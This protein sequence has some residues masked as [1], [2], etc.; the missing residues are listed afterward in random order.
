MSRLVWGEAGTRLFEIGVNRGV[1]YPPN[2][3]A[4]VAWN[5]L[6]AVKES[7]SG[8][9]PQAYYQDGVKYFQIASAEEFDATIEAFS[10]PPEFALCD[11]TANV[12]AGLFITQQ[13][14]KQFG[15]SYCTLVGNDL[16]AE[17]YGY[18]IHLVYGA[19]A[20]PA[21]RSNDTISAS[22]EPMELS[23]DVTTVPQIVPGFKPSAHLIIDSRLATPA[24]LEALENMLY[25]QEGISPRLP[26][27]Q[28][29]VDLFTAAS[30][31]VTDNG[32]GSFTVVGTDVDV[33]N[34]TVDTFRL[35]HPAIID[36]GDGT[37][38]TTTGVNDG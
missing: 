34:P 12:Y 23:W 10:A 4:G 3:A 27:Q 24:H 8:G 5:G 13:P 14:R 28:E 25:G 21:A 19:L 29:L 6:T 26:S 20:K 30:M 35:Y 33:S 32:D 31:T 16:V 38:T 9:E 36:N 18:K 17:T 37:F 11:G 22:T 1:L 15:F 7:P 2:A